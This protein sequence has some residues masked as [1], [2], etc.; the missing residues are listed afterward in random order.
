ML[1]NYTKAQ[2]YGFKWV[3]CCNAQWYDAKEDWNGKETFQGTSIVHT[4]NFCGYVYIEKNP[5][6]EVTFKVKL[7]NDP[8]DADIIVSP[9]NTEIPTECGQWV[10]CTKQQD[11]QYTIR[12]VTKGEDFRIYITD[13]DNQGSCN[14]KAHYN[15]D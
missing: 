11:A 6:K 5:S 9:Q 12:Y 3:D 1:L 13:D 10:F 14:E 8:E 7:L 2:T 4:W 15:K